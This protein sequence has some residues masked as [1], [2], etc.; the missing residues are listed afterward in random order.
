M[1]TYSAK[2]NAA[3]VFEGYAAFRKGTN[4]MLWDYQFMRNT[5]GNKNGVY[6]IFDDTNLH[7]ARI[8][9]ERYCGE[10]AKDYDVRPV[11][12]EVIE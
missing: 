5:E 11:R 9:L 12:I 10:R 4:E 1:D 2:P 7:D 6:L 8:S 3:G